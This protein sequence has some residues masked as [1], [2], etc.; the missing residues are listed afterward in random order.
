MSRMTEM[1]GLH[2]AKPL[3]AAASEF[4]RPIDQ[5]LLFDDF[6]RRE[7][8]GASDRTLL[9]R[10]MSERRVW[11]AIEPARGQDR[12]ERHDP[13]A[14]ALADDENVGRRPEKLA[15]VERAC[16]REAARNLVEDQQR[17]MAVA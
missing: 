14:K 1:A 3:E 11:R 2:R 12:R 7:P 6:E 4:L 17:A 13:P 10:I 8:S 9:V 15:G 5:L 16:S